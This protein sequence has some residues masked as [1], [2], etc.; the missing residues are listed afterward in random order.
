MNLRSVDLN[1]LTLFDAIMTEQNLTRAGDKIGISQPSMSNALSRLR[2]LTGDEL[3]VRSGRGVKPTPKAMLLAGPIRTILDMVVNT[4][5]MDSDFDY[6]ASDRSF[7]LV[8]GD[9]GDVVLMPRLLQ[10]L[11]ELNCKVRI[12][13]LHRGESDYREEMH[14]GKIDL[15][16]SAIPTV[17]E[18][19]HC[20]Q[21]FSEPE[22]SL[23]RRD[24]PEIK[25]SLSLEQFLA[26]EQVVLSAPIRQGFM[27]DQQLRARNLERKHQVTVHSSTEMPHIV[28]ATDM[29]CTMPLSMARQC[30]EI[31]NLKMFPTPLEGVDVTGY[32][33]WHKSLQN[34]AGH[35]W[36]RGL[37]IDLCRRL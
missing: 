25:D 31:F 33:M 23:V 29:I 17:D 30:A 35:K 11:G 26:Q 27:I 4:L 7:N 32:L 13:L 14:F 5:S 28:A 9:F 21:I 16:L 34:D 1:L 10:W 19:I 12:N 36:L 22:Y 2:A 20:E 24:H 37:I 6:Q 3:F 8:L 18:E 15:L